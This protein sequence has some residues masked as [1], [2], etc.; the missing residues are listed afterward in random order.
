[1]PRGICLV[2]VPGCGKSLTA[3]AVATAY[4]VP[5]LRF[6]A[7]A[8][9]SK[10]VGESEGNVRRAFRTIRA[11]GRCVVWFDEIEKSLAGATQGAA[12]GGTSQDQLGVILTEF[13]ETNAGAFMIAT[14]NDVSAL[15]PELLRRFDERFFIDLPDENDRAEILVKTLKGFKRAAVDVDIC[16]VAKACA[17]FTGAEMAALVPN[18]MFAAFNDGARELTTADLLAAAV[19]T[20]PLARTAPEKI[21]RLREWGKTRATPASSVARAEQSSA[22]RSIDL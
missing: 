1:M 18:A 17:D 4:G 5:L 11:I 6:D 3:K 15:P 7:G 9:K 13:Q 22:A 20:V 19:K 14:A 16:A 12:D 2:G 21:T 8:L 10:W